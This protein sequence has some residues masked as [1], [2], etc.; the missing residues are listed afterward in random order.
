MASNFNN[1]VVHYDDGT[2][3]ESNV[4]S[5]LAEET[6]RFRGW[7]CWAGVQNITIDNQGDVYRAICRVGGK[8]GNIYEGFEMPDG[9]VI[10]TKQKST[11][12]A[13]IQL[14]KAHTDHITKL[15]VGKD[16]RQQEE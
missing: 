3:E 1:I 16:D 10:C 8:L 4:N 11:C 7:K 13:D 12:A 2:S 5:L 14:S 9:P 6:N 15:R